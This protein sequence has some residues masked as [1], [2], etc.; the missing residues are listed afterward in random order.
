MHSRVLAASLF[1]V[2]VAALGACTSDDDPD[3]GSSPGATETMSTATTDATTDATDAVPEVEP[4]TGELVQLDTSLRLRLPQEYDWYTDDSGGSIFATAT[5]DGVTVDVGASDVLWD[6]EPLDDAAESSLQTLDDLPG[7]TYRR[8]A[9]T[10]VAGLECWVIEGV[11]EKKRY[12][13]F[14]TLHNG[15]LVHVD[16]TFHTADEPAFADDLVASV[17]ASVEWT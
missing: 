3:A 14:G 17:L 4:A 15:R 5:V 11:G 12:E 7:L 10:T 2:V 1:M 9:N 13:E 16:F 6:V 8:L